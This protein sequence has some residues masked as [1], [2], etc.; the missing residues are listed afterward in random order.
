VEKLV[1]SILSKPRVAI[2]MGKELFYRQRELGMQAA[3]EVATQTMACNMM[4]EAA[5]EGVLAFIEKRAPV[6]EGNGARARSSA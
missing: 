1:T 5:L 6:T 3:Y 4:D 2:V